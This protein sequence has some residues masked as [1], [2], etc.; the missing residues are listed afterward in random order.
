VGGADERFL[1]PGLLALA[2][3]STAMTGLAIAT[4]FERQY[5]VL[6]RLGATPLPRSGLLLAKTLAVVAVELLQAVVLVTGGLATGWS[7]RG[8]R[9]GAAAAVALVLL[10]TACFAGLGLLMA[11]RLRA[12][13][14]LAGANLLYLLLLLGGG[15]VVPLSGLPG[16][17]RAVARWL[18]SSALADGLRAALNGAGPV[19]GR[20]WLVLGLWAAAALAVAARTF[21]WE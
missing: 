5:G 12:E 10:G 1:V 6:K 4:G 18:P 21:R 19:P 15:L 7:Y 2:V 9:S 17:V 14:T 11:G 8:G 16:A 13:A 20:C 3:L